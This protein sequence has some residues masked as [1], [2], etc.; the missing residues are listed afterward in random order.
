MEI[1]LKP[2]FT[3]KKKYSIVIRKLVLVLWG[4]F[5]MTE[6][7]SIQWDYEGKPDLTFGTGA[8]KQEKIIGSVG[9]LVVP[10]LLVVYMYFTNN[11][12]GWSWWQIIFALAIAG[13]IGGGV[14]CNALNSAKRFYHSPVKN[15]EPVWAKNHVMFNLL[16]LHPIVV[17]LV[18]GALNWQY[19]LF[20]YSLLALMTIILDKTPLYLKRPIAMML[21]LIIIMLNSYFMP[22]IPGFE[23]LAPL[24]FI[25]LLV[26][27]NLKEEPYRP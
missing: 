22:S 1:T 16:H 15:G 18:F 23:W 26:S 24:L 25:K 3:D 17:G 20:W 2:G 9:S 21:I 12:F 19:G 10:V 11:Y 4:N 27:H 14:V 7:S 8:I 6:N 5:K 13:D